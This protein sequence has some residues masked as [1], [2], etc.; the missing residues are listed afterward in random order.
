VGRDTAG[1]EIGRNSESEDV[2][3]TQADVKNDELGTND[4]ESNS[5]KRRRVSSRS[6]RSKKMS[7]AD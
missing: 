5:P 4:N 1:V 2:D 7:D 3:D 6:R